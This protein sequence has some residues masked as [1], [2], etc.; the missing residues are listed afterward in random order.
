MTNPW[1]GGDEDPEAKK[2]AETPP[3]PEL[4][5]QQL[6]GWVERQKAKNNRHRPKPKS[7]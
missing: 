6:L 3:A 2:L 5:A 7:R 1:G 4:A